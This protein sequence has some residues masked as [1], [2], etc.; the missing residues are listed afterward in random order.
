MLAYGSHVLQPPMEKLGVHTNKFLGILWVFDRNT[1]K[2]CGSFKEIE[3]DLVY[4]F[5]NS[6][7][8]SDI[9]IKDLVNSLFYNTSNL[10]N[11]WNAILYWRLVAVIALEIWCD[12]KYTCI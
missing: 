8:K 11:Y 10:T 2:Y 3:R 6:L 12:N 1:V 9:N 4:G 7:F 5:I